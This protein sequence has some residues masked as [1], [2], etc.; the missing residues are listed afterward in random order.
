[1]PGGV[2]LPIGPIYLRITILDAPSI[3]CSAIEHQHAAHAFEGRGK[4]DARFAPAWKDGDELFRVFVEARR[5]A[6]ERKRLAR[7]HFE[8]KLGEGGRIVGERF[9]Q[10][11]LAALDQVVVGGSL[12]CQV[13]SRRKLYAIARERE[14]QAVP[15]GYGRI[16]GIAV[17]IHA[18]RLIAQAYGIGPL[19]L[20]LREAR[21][22]ADV[23][24]ARHLAGG[25]Q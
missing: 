1:M 4:R 6:R 23:P 19:G 9:G 11:E 25:T 24:I 14:R 2:L 18:T 22:R 7:S 16:F 3:A 5:F 13:A 21:Y 12:A 8:G 10:D 20:Q 17:G 15:I